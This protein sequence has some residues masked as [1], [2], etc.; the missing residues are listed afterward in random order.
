MHAKRYS[1]FAVFLVGCFL[2]CAGLLS[3]AE[4]TTQK[5]YTEPAS[6]LT[7]VSNR[8]ARVVASELYSDSEKWNYVLQNIATAT[9][10][11]LKVAVA[12]HSGSDAA[13]SEMLSLAV[14]E[15]LEKAPENVFRIT[16]PE[17]QLQLICG[18]LDVDDKR[19]ASYDSAVEA[20]KRRQ[21]KVSTISDAE[22]RKMSKQCI[23]V[24]EESK[25]GLASFYGV[26][27]K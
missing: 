10:L 4:N 15:A 6:I 17:F 27:K 14:G 2:C 11:W 20:I 8:G 18:G 25:I 23:Q 26:N 22:L 1:I 13:I 24:L 21:N 7:D 9:E 12:L 19:Y 16:L 3:A 5:N